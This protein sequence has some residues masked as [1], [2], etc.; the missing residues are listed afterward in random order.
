MMAGFAMPPKSV[1]GV[2]TLW[3]VEPGFAGGENGTKPSSSSSSSRASFH[4]DDPAMKRFYSPANHVNAKSPPTLLIHGLGDTAV[5]IAQSRYVA[6]RLRKHNVTHQLVG[7]PGQ[8]HACDIEPFGPCFR[9]QALTLQHFLQHV[10]T[11]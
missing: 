4:G 7:V 2:V 6:E 11:L 1:S 10:F 8:N 3:G 5:D 9:A